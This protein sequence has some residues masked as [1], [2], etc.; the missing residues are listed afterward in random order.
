MIYIPDMNMN[1]KSFEHVL[2]KAKPIITVSK[3][4]EIPMRSCKISGEHV[5][6]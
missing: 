4:W 1:R 5:K 3:T 2:F 6:I